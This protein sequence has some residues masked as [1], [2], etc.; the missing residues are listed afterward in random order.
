MM[1]FPFY[2]FRR[3]VAYGIKVATRTRNM[4]LDEFVK[5]TLMGITKGVKEANKDIGTPQFAVRHG[6]EIIFDVLLAVTKEDSKGGDVGI[7]IYAAKIGGKTSINEAH[8]S[9]SRVK[10]PVII[11][12]DIS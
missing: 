9:T 12:W 5:Q 4:N 2:L 11:D 1:V 7:N 10:F 6:N 3:G 8:E